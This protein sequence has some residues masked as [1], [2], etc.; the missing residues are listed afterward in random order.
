MCGRF[1]VP[2]EGEDVL[3]N[4]MMEEADRRRAALTESFAVSRGEILPSQCAAVIARS[5]RGEEGAFPML[6]GFHRPDGKGLIINA[7]SE[8]AMEKAMFRPSMELRRCLIPC[9]WY[10]EWETRNAQ[11]SM[12]GDAPGKAARGQTQKIK[13][14]I[15]PSA[16]GLTYLAGIYRYEEKSPLPVF[17][18]LTR[19]AA[20]AIAFIHDRMPVIF[21]EGA[22]EQWL[23]QS[24]DPQKALAL[25]ETEMAYQAV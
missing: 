1:F 14:A 3:L 16:P 13:Y 9:L 23:S 6:W 5:R 18:V 15:R 24:A 19:E 22:K 4:R 11:I 10:F 20:P 8:T 7:R 17:T 25:C 12:L 2:P 21:S